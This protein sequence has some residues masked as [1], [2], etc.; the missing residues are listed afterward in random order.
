MCCTCDHHCICRCESEGRWALVQGFASTSPPHSWNTQLGE[1]EMLLEDPHQ[2]WPFHKQRTKASS[3]AGVTIWRE[4]LSS[5]STLSAILNLGAIVGSAAGQ[6]LV[7][8]KRWITME[9]NTDRFQ[10]S[11]VSFVCARVLLSQLSRM[12]FGTNDNRK[13]YWELSAVAGG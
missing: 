13:V 3:S 8:C 1:K 9:E 2:A 7:L 10:A 12:Y 5:S 11:P 4:M 6:E